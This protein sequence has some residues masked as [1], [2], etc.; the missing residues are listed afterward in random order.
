MSRPIRITEMVHA[1]YRERLAVG[2]LVIDATAGNGYD[3]VFLAEQVLPEGK[4]FIFDIQQDAIDQTLNRLALSHFQD[5][6]I[7]TFTCSHDQM[8]D[9]LSRSC[10]GNVDAIFFNF[11]YLPGGDKALT[12]TQET[13]LRALDH[14]MQLL[15][16][17]GFLSLLIYPGHPTG[18]VEAAAIE[19][20]VGQQASLQQITFKKTQSNPDNSVSPFWVNIQKTV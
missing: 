1:Y 18:A 14:S 9:S 4:L 12:T 7:E 11:G 15:K 5:A 6:L 19:Q 3:S 13:S 8:I 2:N 16:V 17:G 20:W 10:L